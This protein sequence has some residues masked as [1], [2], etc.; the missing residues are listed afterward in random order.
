M[1][2]VVLVIH[3]IVALG[4]IAVVLIQP[5]ESGGFM[6]SSGSMSNLMAPRRRG[7]TLTRVT[8]ILAGTFFVTSLLLAIL[9]EHS[10]PSKSILDVLPVEETAA[11]KVAPAPDDAALKKAA[12][13]EKKK[14]QAPISK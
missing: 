2:S 10:G 6:G 7:D 3:L 4:I 1:E 13:P 14:P 12:V 9:A 8:T 11:E 5:S